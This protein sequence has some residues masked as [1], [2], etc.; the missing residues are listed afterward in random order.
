[1]LPL[2]IGG[3]GL[4]EGVYLGVLGALGV[5]P[6]VALGLSALWL[7]SSLLFAA[8]GALVVLQTRKPRATA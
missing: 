3:H 6:G 8:I 4:R 1:M 2:T 7:A 5:L